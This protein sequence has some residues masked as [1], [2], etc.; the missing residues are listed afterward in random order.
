MDRWYAFVGG[1]QHYW[2]IVQECLR[3]E[4]EGP[5]PLRRHRREIEFLPAV[6]EVTDAPPSPLGRAI[7]LAITGFFTIAVTWASIGEVD[8]IATAQGRVIPSDNIK[9]IQPLETGIVRAIHVRDGQ[10]VKQGDILVELNP[11]DTAADATR[12]ARELITAQ[13]T[14]A[15]LEALLYDD[16][17]D[18]FFP[19][20]GAPDDLIDSNRR[21][22]ESA[23]L[24][25]VARIETVDNEIT[26]RRAEI[27]TTKAEISGLDRILPKV[28]DRV[29]SSG[30]LLEKGFTPRIDHLKLEEELIALEQRRSTAI[31]RL[32]ELMAVL[33][34]TTSRSDQLIAE[35]RRTTQD[36]LAEVAA[37]ADS[38]S[39]ELVKAYDR[40]RQQTLRAPVDGVVQQL[41]IH[42]QGGVVTPAQELMVIVPA[43]DGIVIEAM[44]QN[45]DIGFVVEGQ[46]AEIKVDSFPFT[47]YGTIRGDV[48]TVSRDAVLDEQQGWVYPARFNLW[49]TEIIV[50]NKTVPLSPGM[51]VMAEIKTGKRKL[52]QYLLAPLQEYQ[53]ESLREQ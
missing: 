6:E 7:L 1:L 5:A 23:Y 22:L 3:L 47:K 21:H 52:I 29:N 45:K 30:L 20:E 10:T 19:P 24:E 16:P 13:V 35:E 43:A 34:A 27:S 42:T 26:Q 38:L 18:A 46:D 17:L 25:R 9:I 12:L 37:R 14:V 11:T 28:R 48:K 8:I 44:I 4:K 36:Q 53:S 15:R 31:S 51:T 33:R 40:N 50:G 39:Q 2:K 32:D 49:E 41:A